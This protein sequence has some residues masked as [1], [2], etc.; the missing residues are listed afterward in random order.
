VT[1][2]VEPSRHDLGVVPGQ[3]D[4]DDGEVNKIGGAARLRQMQACAHGVK[5]V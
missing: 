4:A 2:R 5:A 3:H 1:L